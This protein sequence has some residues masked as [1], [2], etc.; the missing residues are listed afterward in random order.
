[1]LGA[2]QKGLRQIFDIKVDKWTDGGTD[3]QLERSKLYTWYLF[4]S[5]GK[6]TQK[7][8]YKKKK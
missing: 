2:I 3:E 8:I 7:Y 5:W 6:H 1:M 4:S